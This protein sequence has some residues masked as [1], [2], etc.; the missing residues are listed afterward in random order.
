MWEANMKNNFPNL[1]ALLDEPDKLKLSESPLLINIPPS[2]KLFILLGVVLLLALWVFIRNV[3]YSEKI[4]ARGFLNN[5]DG[6]TRVY[7]SQRGTML[8]TLVHSGDFVKKGEP[9]FVL[10]T[11]DIYSEQPRHLLTVINHQLLN[12]NSDVLKKK[13]ELVSLRRLLKNGYVT[14]DTLLEKESQLSALIRQKDELLIQKIKLTDHKNAIRSPVDG[15]VTNILATPGQMVDP[16]QLLMNILPKDASLVVELFVP[17][18]QSGFLKKNSEV[19]IHYDAYP[20]AVFGT[21]KAVIKNIGQ[22]VL[23]DLDEL[24]KP[25][26]IKYPYYKVV[27]H[28][29]ASSALRGSAEIALKQGMTLDGIILGAKKTL[30][31]WMMTPVRQRFV[32]FFL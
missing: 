18:A 24:N 13:Q 6:V 15:T 31:S 10:S 14:R 5:K 17:V 19:L 22:S 28:L 32:E 25:L 23:N 20:F 12:Y 11:K 7:S 30:W 26:K 2:L 16:N 21:D 1:P 27:A 29:V 9:L 4:I 8:Q 3:N